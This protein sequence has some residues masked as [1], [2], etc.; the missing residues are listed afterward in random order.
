MDNDGDSDR[1]DVDSCSM[2]SN[3]KVTRRK[4]TEMKAHREREKSDTIVIRT[5][6]SHRLE[7]ALNTPTN[8]NPES[9]ENVKCKG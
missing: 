8:D 2:M 5:R 4:K 1:S 9:R 3:S 6:C 7:V